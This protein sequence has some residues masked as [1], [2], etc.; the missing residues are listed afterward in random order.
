MFL[1]TEELEAGKRLFHQSLEKDVERIKI[2]QPI[3]SARA[4]TRG[5]TYLVLLI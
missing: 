5:I 1:D 3:E 4:H 2:G